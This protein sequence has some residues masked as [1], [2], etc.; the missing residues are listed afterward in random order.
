MSYFPVQASFVHVKGHQDNKVDI[1]KLSLLARLNVE[2]N[3]QAGNFRHEFGQHPPPSFPF[4]QH[5]QL[6]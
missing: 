6:H 4:P 2:A 1:S 5:T 3:T